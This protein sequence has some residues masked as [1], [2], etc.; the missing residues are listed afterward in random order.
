[1]IIPAHER[2][3]YHEF[4]DSD[5]RS[6][7]ISDQFY[8][9][10]LEP[11]EKKMVNILDF[12]CGHGHVALLARRF[13]AKRPNIYIYGCDYQEDLLDVFWS[14]V[15]DSNSSRITP[16]FLP[17]I[18]KVHLPSWLPPLHVV[19]FSFSLS[20]VENIDDVLSSFHQLLAPDSTVIII[21]WQKDIRSDLVEQ[22][23]PRRVR[24]SH[25]Q[26]SD[27]L[28]AAGFKIQDQQIDG[29]SYFFFRALSTL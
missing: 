4:L 28:Q 15:A 23:Y 7:F 8:L 25:Q 17:N 27:S 24:L 22:H 18:S 19:I 12:G 2:V 13:L 1:M 9:D 14:R 6:N 21:D 3:T 11:F 10:I 26:V 5:L 20:T 29:E 16:F